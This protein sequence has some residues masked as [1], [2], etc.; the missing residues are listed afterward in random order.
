MSPSKDVIVIGA[1][2]A[3]LSA[4]IFAARAGASV[5]V[6]ETRSRPGAKIRVSGGGRCNVLPTQVEPADFNSSGSIHALRNILLSWPLGE[7]RA[8]FEEDLGIPLKDEV[9]GKVF[10]QSDRARD[11]VDALLAELQRSGARLVAPFRVV[12]LSQSASGG[13]EVVSDDGQQPWFGDHSGRTRWLPIWETHH[14]T[15]DVG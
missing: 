7:V 8:F 15:G 10:P 2:A 6:V 1:G 5:V 14:E 12:S 3:G 11:V 13:F 4:G 9:S